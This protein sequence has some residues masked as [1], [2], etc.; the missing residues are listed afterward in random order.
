MLRAIEEHRHNE[1]L[2]YLNRALDYRPMNT[3]ALAASATHAYGT[4]A[5]LWH[6]RS[7]SALDGSVNGLAFSPDGRFLALGSSDKTARVI[8]AASG[9]EISKLEFGDKVEAVSFSPDGRYL[10]AGSWDKTARVIEAASGKEISKIVFEDVVRSVCFSPDGRYLAAGSDDITA[11]VME[12]AS[13]K[14]DQAT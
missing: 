2:A 10:A 9:R 7:V 11:R 6:I 5:A 12:A 13:G 14:G 8:E 1:G 4:N 3:E